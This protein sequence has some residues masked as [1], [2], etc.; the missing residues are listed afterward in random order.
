MA[1]GC[2]WL[3]GSWTEP[4]VNRTSGAS[5]HENVVLRLKQQLNE[6]TGPYTVGAERILVAETE[7]RATRRRRN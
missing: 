3:V 2:T 5:N 6:G 7:R 1:H 4:L